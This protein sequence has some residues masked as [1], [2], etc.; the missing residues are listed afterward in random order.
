V[1]AIRSNLS[2]GRRAD[3][4]KMRGRHVLTSSRHCA[5]ASLRCGGDSA[6]LS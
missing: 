5:T 3:V 6:T 4:G 2:M 1:L